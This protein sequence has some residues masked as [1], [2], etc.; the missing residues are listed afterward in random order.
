MELNKPVKIAIA[1]ISPEY[2][3]KEGTIDK[4]CDAIEKAGKEGSKLV[5]FPETFVP[6]YPYW[7]SVTPGSKWAKYMVEYQRNSVKIPDD[8]ENLCE[9]ARDAGVVAIIGVSEMDTLPGSTTLY[10][11]LLFIDSNGE[12]LGKHRKLMPTHGE[13][14]VWGMG[15]GSDLNTYSTDIGVV[16]GLICYENHMTPIKSLLALMGEEIHAAVWPGYWVAEKHT[17]NKRRFDPEKDKLVACDID[18]AIREFAFETQT[19][20]LSANLY[21]PSDVLPEGSF[22]IAAGGSA[23]VNPSGL[24]IVDPI[25]D[26]ETIVYAELDPEERLA[27]KA[28]FDCIGHYSRWDLVQLNFKAKHITPLKISEELT[29]VILSSKRFEDLIKNYDIRIKKIEQLLE[30]LH[31]DTSR[32]DGL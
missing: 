17:A 31:S 29:D 19:F 32:L 12:L 4:A 30:K 14:M 26:E 15:D 27:T 1:Q 24:Y 23:V 7:R 8:T 11:T 3:D 20:V 13:R 21:L 28:Y 18:S 5:V 22:D 10:N 6:G 16:G 2:M 25:F 9:A